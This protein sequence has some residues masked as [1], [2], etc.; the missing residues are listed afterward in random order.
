MEKVSPA[1]R[2]YPMIWACYRE[3]SESCMKMLGHGPKSD[4]SGYAVPSISANVDGKGGNWQPEKPM[5][6]LTQN[7]LSE[8]FGVRVHPDLFGLSRSVRFYAMEMERKGKKIWLTPLTER[9]LE[10]KRVC[11]FYFYLRWKA[12]NLFII[13]SGE[14]ETLVFNNDD[15]KVYWLTHDDQLLVFA[16]SLRELLIND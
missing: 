10:G 5:L 14:A 11:S 3:Y 4:F 9:D 2:W 16:D 13:G 8:Y 1:E 15:G 6:V 12:R 7:E